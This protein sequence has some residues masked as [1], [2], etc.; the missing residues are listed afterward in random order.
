[1]KNEMKQ[2]II[3]AVIALAA[4]LPVIIFGGAPFIIVAYLLA[5]VGLFELLR[6]RKLKLLS[7]PGFLS[8]LVLWVVLLPGSLENSFLP[9][10]FYKTEIVFIAILIFLA[11]TVA[12]KNKFTFDDVSFS[13]LSIVYVGMGFLYFME[14]REISLQS[15]L[16]FGP[17]IRALILSDGRLENGNFGNQSE[18]TV[19]GSERNSVGPCGSTPFLFLCRSGFIIGQ[20]ACRDCRLVCVRT[21]RRFGRIRI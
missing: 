2:R 9:D 1:M 15:F 16:L 17:R 10:K 8:L 20:T 3:T 11:Y 7:V 5:T 6:M 4:F 21:S 12:T 13:L 18:K 19:E 14:I